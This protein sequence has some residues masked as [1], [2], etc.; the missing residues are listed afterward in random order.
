MKASKI[1]LQALK[2]A[3]TAGLLW[4]VIDKF[5]LGAV[6]ERL[7]T[8]QPFWAVAAI[9][10][11]LAQTIF[12]GLRWHHVGLLL[13]AP[14]SLRQ[15]MRFTFIGQFFNQVLPSSV[16]GDGVRTWLVSRSGVS[17]ARAAVSIFC[18]RIAAL[19]MLTIIVA[20]ALPT[21]IIET[22]T[23][24]P[25]IH[26]LALTLPALTALGLFFLFLFGTKLSSTLIKFRLTRPVG[27]L[28]RDLRI[29]LFTPTKSLSITGLAF[30]VQL[31]TVLAIYLCA[32]GLNI[33]L[34]FAPIL[35]L[36]L[37]LLI[38]MVPISF[39]GWGLRETAMIIG[40]G[41]AGIDSQAALAISVAFGV[42]QIIVSL[43][44]AAFAAIGTLSERHISPESP[45]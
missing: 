28:I 7:R 33:D 6:A 29:L 9:A 41:F 45:F 19:V 43:P 35:L 37:I 27:V 14:I 38:S 12:A 5:A 17:I 32:K 31:L 10:A 26:T 25:S 11:L 44:G 8:M 21:L 36:P 42:A 40:L 13:G 18:D 16:G 34:N 30:L 3:V 20:A 22:D 1:G 24:I 23:Q 4:F 15:A 39:A 2:L